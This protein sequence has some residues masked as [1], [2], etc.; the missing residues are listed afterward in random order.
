MSLASLATL[1]Y[2]KVL[3]YLNISS[4]KPKPTTSQVPM[5]QHPEVNR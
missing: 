4:R 2:S 3:V 1:E 5:C